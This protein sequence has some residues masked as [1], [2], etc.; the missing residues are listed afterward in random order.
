[1]WGRGENDVIEA[2][3]CLN[4]LE[5]AWMGLSGRKGVQSH[6]DR[7]AFREAQMSGERHS[8]TN[9]H[10]HLTAAPLSPDSSSF[11]FANLEKIVPQPKCRVSAISRWCFFSALQAYLYSSQI[12]P[13]ILG[14]INIEKQCVSKR[15]FYSELIY[16]KRH[17]FVGSSGFVVKLIR[18]SGG[19]QTKVLSIKELCLSPQKLFCP[20]LKQKTICCDKD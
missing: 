2:P 1:M 18:R 10:A 5:Q 3:I 9:R 4:G 20:Q 8:Q 11:W 15:L 16:I 6:G 13:P 19:W 7:H 17:K 12:Y 14:Q